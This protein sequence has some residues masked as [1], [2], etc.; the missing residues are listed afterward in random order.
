MSGPRP[1][2]DLSR[3]PPAGSAI[4]AALTSLIGRTRDLE[5]VTEALRRCRI[6][7]LSGPGGVGKTRLASEVA[8]RQVRRRLDGVCLIDLAAGPETPEVATE[9]ARVLGLRA[10][11]GTAVIDALRRYL[12]E[13]DLLVVL[14]NCE[15]VIDECAE[16]VSAL[17]GSCPQVRILATSP[18]TSASGRVTV[19]GA[20]VG[21]FAG[22]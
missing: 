13:R 9:T 4:P 2:E 7:T 3:T 22:P 10:S 15:H 16:V 8:R 11:S 20:R 12:G 14:D 19:A 18:E 5:G 6:L 1:E 17:L 21:R